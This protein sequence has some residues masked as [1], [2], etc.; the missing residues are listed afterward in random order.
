MFY[1]VSLVILYGFKKVLRMHFFCIKMKIV[2]ILVYGTNALY[3][4]LHLY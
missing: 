1:K 4:D 2:E 3:R